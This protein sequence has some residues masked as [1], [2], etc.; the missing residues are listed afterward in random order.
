MM[1]TFSV[2]PSPK[3]S[4]TVVEPYNATLS[5]HQLVENSDETFCIDN[6]VRQIT[7]SA[8]HPLT[9]SGSI[10]HLH[11]DTQAVCAIIRRSQPLGLRGDVRCH[12]MLAI[13]RS[14]QFRSPKI[15]RQHGA[16]PTSTLLHGW[17]R[18]PHQPWRTLLPSSHSS[19]AHPANVRPKEHDGSFRFP[20]RPIPDLLSNLPRQRQHERG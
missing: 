11:E 13:P 19:R 4:D 1:A 15:G 16:F 10:R 9:F 6:E 17:F 2:V 7:R 18:T 20:K 14:T 8:K 12:N 5:V 3:V